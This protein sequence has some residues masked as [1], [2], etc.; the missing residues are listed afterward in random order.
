MTPV[1]TTTEIEH[2]ISAPMPD[3]TATALVLDAQLLLLAAILWVA[4]TTEAATGFGGTIIAV[5]F[6][7]RLYPMHVLLPLLVALNVL[8]SSYIVCR[9][10][11][12]VSRRLLL[13]QILPVMGVGLVT[14]LLVFQRASNEALKT[15]FGLF[16]VA[17]AVREL[18]TLVTGRVGRARPLTPATRA[19]GLFA[20]GIAHGMFAC[21]G[22]LLVYVLG[23][24]DLDKHGFRGTLATVWLTL[25]VA[26]TAAYAA[27]GRIDCTAVP[28]LALL[29]PAVFLGIV[30]GEW[31]HRRLDE[32]R[33][34]SAVLVLLVFAG[35]TILV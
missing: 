7:V 12:Q 30:A 29:A 6:G 27:A 34:R 33:F 10:F 18:G 22:P 31:A 14:G 8:L 26:L 2:E 13:R 16:V 11:A 28:V 35:V 25:N 17:V 21:G 3:L 24:S 32:Q 5:T 19:S 15:T 20:A 9:H 4:F 1:D 23:R